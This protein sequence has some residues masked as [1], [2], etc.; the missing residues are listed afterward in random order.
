MLMVFVTH[1]VPEPHGAVIRRCLFPL[2]IG[3][4]GGL[5]PRNM[6]I[7]V[8]PRDVANTDDVEVAPGGDGML[9][10]ILAPGTWAECWGAASAGHMKSARKEHGESQN[11][12][13]PL[14]LHVGLGKSR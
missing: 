5:L 14:A 11:W 3:E 9:A 4:T 13:Q 1:L 10:H 7:R 2:G 6:L 8:N 12:S